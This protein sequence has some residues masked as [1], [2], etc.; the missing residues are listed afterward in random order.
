MSII[1]VSSL[2]LSLYKGNVFLFYIGVFS[3][4]ITITAYRALKL[5]KHR[6][7]DSVKKLNWLIEIISCVVFILMV[8]FAVYIFIKTQNLAAII[9]L[10]FGLIGLSGVR[11]NIR[12]FRRGPKEKLEWLKI[13]LGNM[14]G[15]YIGAFTAFLV[16]QSEYIPVNQI[17]LWLGPTLMIVP[18][19]I[20]ELRKIKNIPI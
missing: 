1:F 6:Q 7:G 4:Y 9:P 2:I 18:L 12:F 20:L 11:S 13:H 10:S 14:M 5:K 16:N 15:S 17:V 8:A 19:I 3:Y